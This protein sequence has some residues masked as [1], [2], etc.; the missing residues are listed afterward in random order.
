MAG[1]YHRLASAPIVAFTVTLRARCVLDPSSVK[2]ATYIN[3]LVVRSDCPP[4]GTF[5][6][7]PFQWTEQ[8]ESGWVGQM[9]DLPGF[10]ASSVRCV[11]IFGSITTSLALAPF[12]DAQTIVLLNA[13]FQMVRL[14]ELAFKNPLFA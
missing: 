8:P 5:G 7:S 6:K 12:K 14:G 1:Q 9:Y 10:R 13:N 2:A 3:G 4:P 11:D